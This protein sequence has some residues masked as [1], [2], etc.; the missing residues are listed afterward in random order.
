M[1]PEELRPEFCKLYWREQ[2]RLLV[3]LKYG[4]SAW[5]PLTPAGKV[6]FDKIAQCIMFDN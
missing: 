1:I 2:I 6:L 3:I 4:T 5:G